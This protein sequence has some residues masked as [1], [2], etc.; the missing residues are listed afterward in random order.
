MTR[1]RFNISAALA[2]WRVREPVSSRHFRMMD[3]Q[4]LHEKTLGPG[5]FDSSWDL[6]QGLA[7]EVA[8]PGDPGFQAWLEA[9][10]RL[11]APAPARD[12]QAVPA[13][14]MLEFEPVD[15]KAWAPP[16]VVVDPL[17]KC[18]PAGLELPE[19]ALEAAGP[20]TEPVLELALV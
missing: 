4:A 7:V 20:A 10:A 11:L 19:L 6:G 3:L 1:I 9:Q 13:E 16:N 2:R 5:W 15:W 14:Q 17:P 18:L 8:G 12:N